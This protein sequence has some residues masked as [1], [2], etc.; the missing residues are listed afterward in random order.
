MTAAC[1]DSSPQVGVEDS[2]MV[3]S[4]TNESGGPV[5]LAR[6]QGAADPAV[7]EFANGTVQSFTVEAANAI[8]VLLQK[9]DGTAMLIHGGARQ[10]GR[11]TPAAACNI[12]GVALSIAP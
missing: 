3:I 6:R 5:N 12:F 8:E 2:R 11:H 1:N 7:I 10:V 9:P 4:V